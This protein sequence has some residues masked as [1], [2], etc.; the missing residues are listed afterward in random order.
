MR[1]NIVKDKNTSEGIFQNYQIVILALQA[2]IKN[3][4]NYALDQ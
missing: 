2:K 4:N 3:L 1:S